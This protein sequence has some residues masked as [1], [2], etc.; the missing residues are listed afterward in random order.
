MFV[1]VS[2]VAGCTADASANEERGSFESEIL[3]LAF[4]AASAMPL[5]P[6]IKNKSRAQESIVIASLKVGD[7][8]RA[9]RFAK[10]IPNWRRGLGVAAYAY[11]CAAKGLS[12]EARIAIGEANG[13]LQS[14]LD[15]PNEQTWRADRIRM[16]IEA[17][18]DAVD[19]IDDPKGTIPFSFDPRAA[20]AGAFAR[21]L[22]D[23]NKFDR[24]EGSLSGIFESENFSAVKKALGQCVAIYEYHYSNKS[25]RNSMKNFVLN[26]YKRLPLAMRIDLIVKLGLAALK[27]QDLDE[28]ASLAES[29]TQRLIL[30][31]WRPRDEIALRA[32]IAE[33]K[34]LS[35]R[36]EGARA[37][38]KATYQLYKKSR[39]KIVSIFRGQALRPL[40]EA[41]VVMGDESLAA[42]IY[43][44]AMDEALVNPN[45]RPRATE[46]VAICTSMAT[47]HFPWHNDLESKA[48]GIAAA[49][50]APW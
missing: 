15:H 50:S 22:T 8:V 25:R 31:Q 33:L 23:A 30:G 4:S 41:F 19:Q 43:S 32:R 37:D 38:A 24:F 14:I 48:K 9:K 27:N 5:N 12:S 34:F 46:L 42:E 17:A 35:G 11:Y 10:Q 36:L 28:G 1:A 26:S 18:E 39:L 44:L 29:A 16:V 47:H 3:D 21:Q 6:H 7:P 20:K 2:L 45:S 40:A 49:L 13:S